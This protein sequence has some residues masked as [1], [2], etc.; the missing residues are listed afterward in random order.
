MRRHNIDCARL[1]L[2]H[3]LPSLRCAVL[4]VVAGVRVRD[5]STF[6]L[7]MPRLTKRRKAAVLRERIIKARR[8]VIDPLAWTF[9][10]PWKSGDISFDS[11]VEQ[12]TSS[13]EESVGESSGNSS[14]FPDSSSNE[15]R[16]DTGG[17]SGTNGEL[18]FD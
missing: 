15:I 8:N 7:K 16:C 12:E 13:G 17:T 4:S 3:Y 9:E 1:L 6:E 14:N 11:E 18:N 2:M 5:K 10:N